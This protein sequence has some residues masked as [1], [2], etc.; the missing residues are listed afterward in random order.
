MCVCALT[1]SESLRLLIYIYPSLQLIVIL[2][3]ILCESWG[4]EAERERAG[5]AW[6]Q[7]KEGSVELRGKETNWAEEGGRKE[8]KS[9]CG[10][11]G[12]DW[13]SRRRSFLLRLVQIEEP[14][15]HN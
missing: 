10:G 7:F 1:R 9:V 2:K 14:D 8:D 3:N 4:R 11:V 12:G 15:M 5:K 6:N 13:G